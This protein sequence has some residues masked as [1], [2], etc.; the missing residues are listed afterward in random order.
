MRGAARDLV[1]PAEQGHDGVGGKGLEFRG[2]RAEAVGVQPAGRAVV[3]HAVV[4]G[5]NRGDDG[6]DPA[7]RVMRG[8]SA[9]EFPGAHFLAVVRHQQRVH[10]V[11]GVTRWEINRE[12]E[13]ATQLGRVHGVFFKA[14]AGAALEPAGQAGEKRGGGARHGN[15]RFAV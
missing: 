9:G 5:G 6:R 1:A 8:E 4:G 11:V 12:S 3:V 14:H 2:A 7:R 13:A 15:F 10:V